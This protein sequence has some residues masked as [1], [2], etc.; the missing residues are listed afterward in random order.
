MCGSAKA[1]SKHAWSGVF[2]GQRP[3]KRDEDFPL[4]DRHGSVLESERLQRSG[5]R[6][7]RLPLLRQRKPECR[8]VFAVAL[9]PDTASVALDDL[10]ANCQTHSGAR[11][12]AA[13]QAFEDA[14]NMLVKSRLD[15]NAVVAHRENPLVLRFIGTYVNQRRQFTSVFQRIPD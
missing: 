1:A 7:Y 11:H 4:L 6:S 15:A 9:H 2:T 10:P 12:F 8:A 5:L 13:M 14:E 3:A